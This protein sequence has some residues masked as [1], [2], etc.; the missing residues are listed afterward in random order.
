MGLGGK[1][2][3]SYFFR[4]ATYY[5]VTFFVAYVSSFS[6][7]SREMFRDFIFNLGASKRGTPKRKPKSVQWQSVGANGFFSSVIFYSS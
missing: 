3:G 6:S 5:Y 2:Y 7:F 4:S 1:M